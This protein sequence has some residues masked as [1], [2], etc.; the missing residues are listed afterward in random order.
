M[1]RFVVFCS[2]TTVDVEDVDKT[3]RI[4]WRRLVLGKEIFFPRRIG[5]NGVIIFR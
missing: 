1:L 3:L 2:A 5:L 4:I